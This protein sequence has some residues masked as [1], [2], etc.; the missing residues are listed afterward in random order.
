MEIKILSETNYEEALLGMSLSYYDHETPVEQWWDAEKLAKADKRVKLLAFKD[1]G[2]NKVLESINVTIYIQASRSFWSEFDTYRAGITKQSAS[3]MHTLDKRAVTAAD[4]ESGTSLATIDA[5]N[6]CLRLYWDKWI[7][8]T[9]LKNNLPEGW[10][11]ERVVTTNYKTLQNIIN[12]RSKHR[13]RYWKQ[14]CQYILETCKH[15]ELLREA[16]V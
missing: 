2:H 16:N 3:T 6:R 14:F 10:L 7:D 5:F 4:F 11:Q 9:E 12:Q 1:G 13:L 8:L 15:P